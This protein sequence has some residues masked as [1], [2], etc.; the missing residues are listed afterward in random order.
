MARIKNTDRLLLGMILAGFVAWTLL[1]PP[2]WN[3]GEAREGLV[4]QQI[5]RSHQW[6]LPFRNGEVPSKPPLFHWI[7]AAMAFLFGLSDFTVRLPSALAAGV[8][9]VTTFL[10][11]MATGGRKT[12]WLAVGALLGMYQFWISG[13]EARVDM[14]FAACVTVSLAGFFFWYRD[15]RESGR[16]ACYFAAAC[17]VLAKGPAGI[18]LPGLVIVGFL[19]A[20]G[21]LRL[22]WKFW[23]WPLVGAALVIDVGWYALAYH[24]GGS[25]FIGFQILRENVDRFFGTRGFSSRNTKLSVLAWIATRTFPWNLALPW[26]LIRRLSGECEDSTGRLLHAWWIALSALIFLAAGKRAVYLLPAYPAIALLAARALAAAISSPAEP[27]RHDGAQRLLAATRGLAWALRTPK[28]V[29]VAVVLLDLALVL[30]NPMVWK[31]AGA[32]KSTVAFVQEIG[33]I[34]PSASPLFAASDFGNTNL[35]IIAYR[36]QRRIERRP[37][38]C[39]GPNDYFLSRLRTLDA[40]GVEARVLAASEKINV[41]LVTV[42]T[43]RQQAC[44]S[45]APA[46]EEEDTADDD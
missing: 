41:A 2:I 24:V 3:H 27:A 35:Y 11:G 7:A 34:V 26:A 29:I 25:R 37:L 46:V 31:R 14:V 36:L 1:L 28:R 12:A 10:L 15:A 30:L 9:L 33:A 23:S 18:A 38:A 4:V 40:A 32:Y 8:V 16:A 19:A 5:V 22:L 17:A 42:P 45:A 39:A 6:I 44:P 13:T 20:E 21:R 43:L